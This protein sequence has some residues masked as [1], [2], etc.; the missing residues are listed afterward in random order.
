M[1]D[2]R[3]DFGRRA[4]WRFPAR[5]ALDSE[6]MVRVVEGVGLESRASHLHMQ[7]SRSAC[8][9]RASVSTAGGVVVRGWTVRVRAGERSF[10]IDAYTRD[11]SALL[12]MIDEGAELL[13][14]CGPS[15]RC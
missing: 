14:L 15:A 13:L 11:L 3:A 8:V 7:L 1:P 6:R 2:G 4:V 12:Q 9:E 10:W 5:A